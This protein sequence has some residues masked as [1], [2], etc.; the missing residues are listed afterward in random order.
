MSML[1]AIVN[2]RT[3]PLVVDCLRSLAPEVAANPGA[4]V[5]VVDNASG[6]GSAAVIAEAIAAHGW[7]GWA[8]LIES[9]VNGGFAAGVNIALRSALADPG[10]A[11]LFWLLNPDT[12]VR[13]GAMA[14]LASFMRDRPR[15]GIAGSLLQLADG[16]PWPYAFRFPTVLSE[17]EHGM[18]LG[19]ATRLLARYVGRRAMGTEAARVDWVSGASMVVRRAVVEAVGLMDEAYF[20]YFEETDFCLAAHRAGWEC[21]YVPEARVMHIAGQSTGMAGVGAATKR[22]P[23]Y[24]FESRRR[25]FVK[26]HGAG[27]AAAVD[28]AWLA[29]HATWTARRLVTGAADNDPPHLAGDIIRHS[30]LLGRHGGVAR[31]AA[32]NEHAGGPAMLGAR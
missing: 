17:L 27:Y 24:W 6:D 9:P 21:W 32:R 11:E 5:L 15:V 31:A 20:L 12:V 10:G 26:N 8:A 2:Y 19:L 1:V 7:D 18:R 29:A 13:P 14:V 4:R 23:G 30:P 22:R 25:Y 16:S 28:F 3:G